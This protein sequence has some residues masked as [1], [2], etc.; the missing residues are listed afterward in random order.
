MSIKNFLR[1]VAAV[2]AI[3]FVA[4]NAQS[5]VFD[6][7]T[8]TSVTNQIS[9]TTPSG[10]TWAAVSTGTALPVRT[11]A[12]SSFNG[13]PGAVVYFNTTNGQ[14]QVD[15]RGYDLNALIITFTSGTVNIGAGTPG[16][17][18]YATG[19]TTNAYSPTTG[20]PK[21]FPAVQA[22]FGLPPTT[23]ASRV[24]ETVGAPLS[25]SLATSGDPGNIASTTG[26]WNGKWSFPFDLVNTGSNL[27]NSGS[28]ASMVISDFKTIGQNSQ[29]NANILG[30]GL[31]FCTFQYGING[32][33][34]TQ[35]GAVI[36]VAVPEPSTCAMAL[37][38]LACGGYSMFRR[39]RTR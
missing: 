22:V 26:F 10:L 14:L 15:P 3:A 2:T 32:A 35:V 24:G 28:V 37:A 6:Q 8:T 34:G 31:G 39:R 9:G 20:T 30:Y 23:F 17:F 19:T 29:A 18:T 12:T 33:T 21:T 38:G 25:P 16:P 1:S 27:V 13:Q 5:G 4:S 36:P 7:P 11:S